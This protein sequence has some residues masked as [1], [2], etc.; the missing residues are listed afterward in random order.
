MI[1]VT[2]IGQL[3]W[4]VRIRPRWTCLPGRPCRSEHPVVQFLNAKMWSSGSIVGQG[5][6]LPA[7][8]VPPAHLQIGGGRT[9]ADHEGVARAV[10]YIHGADTGVSI[11]HAVVRMQVR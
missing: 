6:P 9:F 8:C 11:K 2:I 4:S 5:S 10:R 7:I 1:R 3:T